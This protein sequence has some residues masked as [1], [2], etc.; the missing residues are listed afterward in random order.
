MF[1]LDTNVISELRVVARAHPKVV[2]WAS[3]AVAES[4]Y[5]SAITVLELEVGIFRLERKDP[6]GGAT[7]RA[8]F[9]NKILVQFAG[10]ILP[11]DLRVARA[12][13]PLHAPCDRPT[14]DALIAATAIVHGM[15]VVTRNEA[16]F[17]IPGVKVLNPWN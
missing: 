3:T 11:P 15:T 17:K 7:L 12:C 2:G 6:V 9:E 4:V 10:R 8:W 5:L 14:S 13:A 1:L 16:D